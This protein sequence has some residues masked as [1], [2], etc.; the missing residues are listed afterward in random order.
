MLSSLPDGGAVEGA[1][2]RGNLLFSSVGHILPMTGT[3]LFLT[4]ALAVGALLMAH[5]R[6]PGA[7]RFQA[8]RPW[9]RARGSE[10]AAGLWITSAQS[11]A[12]RRWSGGDRNPGRNAIAAPVPKEEQRFFA[13]LEIDQFASLRSTV[14]FEIANQIIS[15]VVGRIERKISG[16]GLGR[17]GHS[18]IEFIFEAA[19]RHEAEQRLEQCLD[20][21]AQPVEVSGLVV[22]LKGRVAYANC[23]AHSVSDELF[24]QVLG[25]LATAKGERHRVIFADRAPAPASMFD[26]LEILRALPGALAG[27][28]VSLFYQPKFEC[29]EERFDSA[30]ALLRWSSPRFG[31]VPPQQLVTLAE[32]TGMIRDLTLWVL[33]QAARDQA[34]LRAEGHELTIFVNVSGILV[35]DRSFTAEALELIEAAPGRMGIEI[36]E[37]AVI[38]DPLAAIENITAYSGAGISVAIDDFGSGLSS[39]AYLKRL[40]VQELKIDKMFVDGL[41]QSHRDPLIVRSAIDLAHA[42]EMRVTAEG[43]DDPMGFSLLRVMGCDKLQGYYI[44]RPMPLTELTRFLGDEA[45]RAKLASP[46]AAPDLTSA[47]AR[48]AANR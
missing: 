1:G 27:G 3:W 45:C 16:A 26:E 35:A 46:F 32:R 29:R 11:R 36:T 48:S 20:A 24:D 4:A 22:Q 34:A 47:M 17:S 19:A 43:V 33:R 31:Q 7:R 10:Q 15:E 40:P 13:L 28:E 12:G 9:R 14:G 6:G 2:H 44:A 37:T 30:E 38:N 8:A 5:L 39:L 23:P 18:T 21:I 41:T 25:M 42:M